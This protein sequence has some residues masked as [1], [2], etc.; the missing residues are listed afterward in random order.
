VNFAPR[1]WR[2]AFG[3]AACLFAAASTGP[4]D[5][6]L[7]ARSFFGVYR[8]REIDDAGKREMIETNGTTLHGVE[9]LEPGERL[10][11]LGYYSREGPFGRFF[12]ALPPGSVRHVAV[13]GLGIGE[14]GCYAQPGQDWM[15]YEI[16]PLVERV[17]RDSRYFHLLAECG[18]DPRVI[19]G[20]ARQTLANAPDGSYD[21]MVLDAFTS[22]TIPIHLLT[23]EALALYLR[24]LAP[25]GRIIF[26]LS[27]RN[28]D[29]R[30]VISAL[31]NDAGLP[32]RA[33]LYRPPEGPAS[34]RRLEVLVAVVAGRGGDL[35]DVDPAD[36]WAKLPPA[37]PWAAWTDQ[38]SDLLRVIHFGG[39]R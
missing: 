12:A 32:S 38:R 7:S 19:L 30:P 17:A 11:P 3:V 18:N 36:G 4:G 14:L 8:V 16:D 23:R 13:V 21:V 37:E 39:L 28:F 1:R 25:G 26:H 24:K 6:L 9:S 27:S 34:L 20:D 15:F 33:M 5:S 10:I 29:L 2:F 31:A 22:D 35:N